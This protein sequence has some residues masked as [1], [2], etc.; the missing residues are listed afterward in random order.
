MQYVGQTCRFLNP[1][2]SEHYHLINSLA[3]MIIFFLGISN[4]L[5]TLLAIFLF[6]LLK[7]LLMTI[8]PL[9]DVEIFLGMN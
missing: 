5:I 2:F 9:K 7:R 3:K 8:I 1:R 4:T 6:S